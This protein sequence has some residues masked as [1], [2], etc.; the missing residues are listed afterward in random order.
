VALLLRRKGFTRVRPLAG[1]LDG[2]RDL[3]FPVASAEDVK[4]AETATV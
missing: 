1:G 4:P 2:W 3:G